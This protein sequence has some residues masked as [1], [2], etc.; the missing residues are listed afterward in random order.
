MEARS[1]R[2]AGRSDLKILRS[3]L[4]KRAWGHLARLLDSAC[5]KAEWILLSFEAGA[6]ADVLVLAAPSE[7][8]LPL[9][10]VRLLGGLDPKNGHSF[11]LQQCVETAKLLGVTELYCTVAEDSFEA[12]SLVQAG[13]C[14][15]R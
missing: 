5:T 14:R 11:L 9:E 12:S 1:R 4:E 15:W 3:E 6:L 13:F 2:V 10:I 7:F 8:N